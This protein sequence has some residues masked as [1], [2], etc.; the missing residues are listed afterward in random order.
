MTR[1][2]AISAGH[3]TG[4]PGEAANGLVEHTQAVIWRNRIVELLPDVARGVPATVTRRRLEFI[5]RGGFSAAVEIHF[6]PSDSPHFARVLYV[7]GREASRRFAEIVQ[8]ELGEVLYST[9]E[10]PVAE[11]WYRGQERLG[12]D[13]FLEQSVP[14][15][16]I[17]EPGPISSRKLVTYEGVACRAIAFGIWRYLCL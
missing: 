17:V 12:V 1:L 2:V 13:Y 11:G 15:A 14:S 8:E 6:G 9:T 5:N 10:Q 16:I 3:H 7:P 4:K